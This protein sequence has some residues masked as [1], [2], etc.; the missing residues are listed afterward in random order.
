M[1]K[2]KAKLPRFC[3][4]PSKDLE[5]TTKVPCN[6]LGFICHRQGIIILYNFEGVDT[7]RPFFLLVQAY[8]TLN[9]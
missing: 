7:Y 5:S 6:L 4:N 2:E 1:H 9:T 8:F 3:K